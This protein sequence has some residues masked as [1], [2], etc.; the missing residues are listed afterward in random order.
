MKGKTNMSQQQWSATGLTCDHC[1][2][3]VTKNLSALAGVT[4][5]A[6]EVKPNEAS[7]IVTVAER[8][9]SADEVF[10]ALRSAGNYVL[11]R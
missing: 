2:Q 4:S 8:E 5:V 3:S 10:G 6:I 1:S 7:Q 11:V 9:L